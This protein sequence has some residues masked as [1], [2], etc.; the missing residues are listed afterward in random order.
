MKKELTLLCSGENGVPT[1]TAHFI[2]SFD[3]Q[4][5]E[6]ILKMANIK[7]SELDAETMVAMKVD[8]GIPW[9]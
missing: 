6:N 8:L 5:R 1:Q 9:E 2:K 4:E 7:S 3:V